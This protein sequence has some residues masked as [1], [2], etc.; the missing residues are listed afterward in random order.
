[1]SETSVLAI[2]AS[3]G[4]FIAGSVTADAAAL[5]VAV[6]EQTPSAL[7][8]FVYQYPESSLAPDALWLAAEISHDK[9]SD[10]AKSTENENLSCTVTIA[11]QGGGKAVVT[12]T[13]TG[14]AKALLDPLGFKKGSHIPMTGTKTIDAGDYTRVD[15]TAIDKDGHVIKCNV[16]LSSRDG[17]SA[18]GSTGFGTPYSYAP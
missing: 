4:I 14:A 12:W 3:V 2:L 6:Q 9:L 16:V 17:V 8:N 7:E 18:S 1:M 15:I 11:R 13:I 5:A 10:T